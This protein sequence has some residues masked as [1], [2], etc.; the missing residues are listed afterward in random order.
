VIILGFA[1]EQDEEQVRIDFIMDSIR[2]AGWRGV[3]SNF[4]APLIEK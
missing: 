2:G 4:L 3:R 1:G